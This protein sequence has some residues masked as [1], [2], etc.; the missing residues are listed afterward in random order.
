MLEAT[1]GEFEKAPIGKY[2][3]TGSA[4]VWAFSPS[5]VGWHI[6]GRPDETETRTLLRLMSSYT[7]LASS[8]D[9]V[10]D[11]R[12]I[13]VVNPT[14]LPLLV[15]WLFQHRPELR[16]RVGVQANVIRRDG[17]GFLLMGIIASLGDMHPFETYT[18]PVEAF[19]AI[20][21]APGATL[22]EEV[23]AVVA[24]VRSTPRELQLLRALLA[25]RP[26]HT[27]RTAA[28]ELSTSSRSL[29]RILGRYG[30]SFHDEQTTARF[31]LAKQLLARS[32]VKIAGVA[33]RVG[34]SVRTLTAVFRA[35][36]GLTPAAWRKREPPPA[37]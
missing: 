19:R 10:A 1:P 21:G 27:I 7:K 35:K 12:G 13:E 29:Q 30:T 14:A 18:D 16:L 28:R 9:I 8:F 24:R 26:D 4:V 36:L 15:A 6:W 34:W 17:I 33:S 25:E 11:S 22:C 32:D 3:C 31:E 23:E 20:A 5:L 2:T 37:G